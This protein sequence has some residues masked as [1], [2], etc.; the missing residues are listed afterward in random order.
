MVFSVQTTS[1]VFIFLTDQSDEEIVKYQIS[2]SDTNAYLLWCPENNCQETPLASYEDTTL[3]YGDETHWW[4][5]WI[6]GVITF[7]QGDIIGQ[8][9]ILEYIEDFPKYP[10]CVSIS[11]SD[12]DADWTFHVPS[13]YT[14]L[15]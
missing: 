13:K 3:L 11:G 8:N 4:L 7:G 2:L 9:Q 5:S 1:N 6:G 14:V 15:P 12:A 10:S